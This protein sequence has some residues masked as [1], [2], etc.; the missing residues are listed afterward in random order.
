MNHFSYVMRTSLIAF[1]ALMLTGCDTL[2]SINPFSGSN[3]PKLQGKR[4][5]VLQLDQA[6]QPDASIAALPVVAPPVTGNTDWPQA[7]GSTTHALGNLALAPVLTQA[8]RSSIGDGSSSGVKLLVQPI[9]VQNTV[10]ALDTSATVSARSTVDGDRIWRVTISP[11]DAREETLGGG[12]GYGDGRL[13]ATAG[14]PEVLALNPGTG[15]VIWRYQTTAPTRGAPTY[16]NGRLFVLTIDNQLIALDAATG[17]EKWTNS[18]VQEAEAYLSDAGSAAD[19]TIVVAPYSSGEVLALRTET[20]KA[21]W[22]DNLSAVRRASALWSLTDFNGLPIIDNGKVYAVSVS[23]RIVAIDERTGTRLWQQE[24]GSSATPWVAG[25]YLYMV[26]ADDQLIAMNT[27][28]NGG[29]RWVT[30]L[31]R[32]ETPDKRE[33]PIYW[34]GPV[35]AGGRLIMAN[36]ASQLVEISLANGSIIKTTPLPGPVFVQPVVANGTLYLIT[37]DGDLLAYR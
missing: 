21:A 17:K 29:I 8:W 16:S 25:D 26:S 20:G 10:F 23:G 24:I 6:I 4:L 22:E 37:D 19:N 18:G 12:L 1:A 14:Y 11:E 2:D 36:S 34:T 31:D 35:M 15:E 7:G 32:Y 28:R 30:Q 3:D 33:N 5:P 9:V 13:Y 27:A